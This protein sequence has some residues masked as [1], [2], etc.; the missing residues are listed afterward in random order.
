MELIKTYKYKLK[1]TKQQAELVYSWIG[2]CRYV[3]NLAKETKETAFK[4]GVK[5]SKFDLMN[6]LPDLKE[7]EWIKSVPAQT[8]Q[9][10]L[11]GSVAA[12]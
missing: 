9:Q 12:G 5:L 4:S 10:C 2:A 6:Q 3:F 1:L 11:S 7:V 8:L